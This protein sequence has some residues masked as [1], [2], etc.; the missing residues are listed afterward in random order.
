MSQGIFTSEAA[1]MKYE[2]RHDHQSWY[3]SERW[4]GRNEM[5]NMSASK[6]QRSLDRVGSTRWRDRKSRVS[7]WP[8]DVA[9]P[10]GERSFHSL[11]PMYLTD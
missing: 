2:D 5:K 4:L 10:E 1:Q 9:A 3:R 11:G 8:T 7:G 6:E